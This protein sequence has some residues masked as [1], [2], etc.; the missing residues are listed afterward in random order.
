MKVEHEYP[1]LRVSVR[2]EEKQFKNPIYGLNFPRV[3]YYVTT[4]AYICG[5]S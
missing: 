5:Q 3:F 2:G 1:I 4:L